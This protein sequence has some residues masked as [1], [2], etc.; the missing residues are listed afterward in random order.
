M[1]RHRVGTREDWT[2]ARKESLER[3][4]EMGATRHDGDEDT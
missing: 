2:A 1:T 4:A 3:E